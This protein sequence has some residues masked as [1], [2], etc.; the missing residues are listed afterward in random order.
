MQIIAVSDMHGDLRT[1]KEL[2]SKFNPDMLLCCGDWGNPGEVHSDDISW[3]VQQTHVL[4]VFGNHDDISLLSSLHNRDG[5]PIL[6]QNGEVRQAG[7]ITITGINGIWAKSHRQPW[8]ITDEEVVD[9]AE[10]AGHTDIFI[11]H[12]CAIGLADLFPWGRRGGQRCFLDAFEIIQPNVYIC[13]HLHVQ[14]I[15]QLKDG[16]T[17]A[18]VGNTAQGEYLSIETNSG[19][20]TVK[21]RK[22][23]EEE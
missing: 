16:R 13:G 4:T 3:L 11:T 19:H 8:Y 17:A 22:L 15:K 1:V 10:K 20:W 12:G 5:S 7:R 6:L 14:Q 23:G 21:V 9:A 2:V 18:N